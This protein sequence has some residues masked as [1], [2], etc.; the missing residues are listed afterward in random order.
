MNC[1]DDRNVPRRD[2]LGH[3]ATH[4]NHRVKHVERKPDQPWNK[5]QRKRENLDC[6]GNISEHASSVAH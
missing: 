5:P 4:V 3:L 1:N 6:G 2:I